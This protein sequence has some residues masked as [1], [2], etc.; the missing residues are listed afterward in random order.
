MEKCGSR[1]DMDILVASPEAITPIAALDES[2][3]PTT[4]IPV[5]PVHP[6]PLLAITQGNY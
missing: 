4:D 1:V 6:L 5:E 2:E 3:K